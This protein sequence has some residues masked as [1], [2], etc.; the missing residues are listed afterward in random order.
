MWTIVKA[1]EV[2]NLRWAG[3]KGLQN[4]VCGEENISVLKNL[5]KSLI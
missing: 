4:W 1:Y 2:E 3:H 5:S